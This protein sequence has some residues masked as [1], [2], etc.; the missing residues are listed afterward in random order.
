MDLGGDGGQLGESA[1][2]LKQQVFVLAFPCNPVKQQS[3]KIQ[4]TAI[5]LALSL[6]TVQQGNRKLHTASLANDQDLLKTLQKRCPT[7][8]K[9]VCELHVVRNKYISFKGLLGPTLVQLTLANN[10]EPKKK[11]T[12][13]I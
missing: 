9:N 2:I 6:V 8:R 5:N 11:N 4:N 3:L 10:I 12:N 7:G 1:L 13:E